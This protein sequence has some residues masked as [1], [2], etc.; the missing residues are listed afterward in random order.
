MKKIV[1]QKSKPV[2]LF[3][4]KFDIDSLNIFLNN[5]RD[6]LYEAIIDLIFEGITLNLSEVDVI[7]FQ[8]PKDIL[9]FKRV[10][11][12]GFLER[13]L[14]Y[15]LKDE[16]YEICA[17]ISQVE[18]LLNPIKKKRGRKPKSKIT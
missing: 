18:K 7:E 15:F 9:V 8:N 14:P 17:K 2:K 5:N 1:T 16:R 13:A 4:D 3:T 11:W 12:K 10:E 6:L